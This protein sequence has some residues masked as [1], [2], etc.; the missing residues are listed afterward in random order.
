[1]AYADNDVTDGVVMSVAL[2]VCL[3]SG[4]FE[5]DDDPPVA[6][7]LDADPFGTREK[8]VHLE[9]GGDVVGIAVRR[10]SSEWEFLIRCRLSRC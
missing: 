4:G 5:G 1:M 10:H 8:S 7:V 3:H 6:E 2:G 9:G